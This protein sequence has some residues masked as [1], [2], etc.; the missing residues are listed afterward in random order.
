MVKYL[1]VTKWNTTIST[2]PGYI[3]YIELE[4]ILFLIQNNVPLNSVLPVHNIA[5][6]HFDKDIYEKYYTYIMDLPRMKPELYDTTPTDSNGISFAL[7]VFAEEF[8]NPIGSSDDPRDH[9]IR[10]QFLD[11]LGLAADRVAGL[12]DISEY[13][14]SSKDIENIYNV[15]KLN[16]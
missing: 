7:G 5:P 14:G 11:L 4:N 1:V 3:N 6:E 15:L 10:Q 8:A 13:T 2:S 9:F 12:Y 16:N